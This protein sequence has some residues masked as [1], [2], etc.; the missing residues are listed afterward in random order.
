MLLVSILLTVIGYLVIRPK[1]PSYQGR[2]LTEWMS[3]LNG[4]NLLRRTQAEEAIREMKG[5]AL[6]YLEASLSHT[7]N[8]SPS[9][10]F[11]ERYQNV[12]QMVH[13]RDQAAERER[14]ELSFR[15]LAFLGPDAL[16]VLERLMKSKE[17]IEPASGLL[18]KMDAVEILAKGTAPDRGPF[19]RMYAV[20]ALGG[21]SQRKD[22]AVKLLTTLTQDPEARVSIMATIT[23]GRLAYNPAESVPKLRELLGSK[24]VGLRWCAVNALK[25]FGTNAASAL[26]DL[27]KMDTGRIADLVKDRDQ[28]IQLITPPQTP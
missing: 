19:P 18:A 23:L 22:Q 16:P 27:R 17:T 12:L 9:S 6:S 24:N 10:K 20:M 3:D 1:E 8:P 4:P 2:A 26:P 25:G 28:A 11:S 13:L 7:L 15:V 21:V 5:P 14:W